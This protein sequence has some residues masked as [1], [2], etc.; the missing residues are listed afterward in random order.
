MDLRVQL[1]VCEG[2]GCLWYRAQSHRGVY[3][4]GCDARLKQ[5]P[6]AE[7][8]RRRGPKADKPLISIWAVAHHTMNEDLFMGAS[9]EGAGGVE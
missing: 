7:S 4:L 2:C 3:C 1:K 8:R 5:F 6:T 9:A